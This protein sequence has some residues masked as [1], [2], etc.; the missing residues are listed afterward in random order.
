MVTA[1]YCDE[2]VLAYLKGTKMFVGSRE[3]V[4]FNPKSGKPISTKANE[5]IEKILNLVRIDHRLMIGI[6]VEML[7]VNKESIRKI[8]RRFG[9]EKCMREDCTQK[10]LRTTTI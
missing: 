8:F 2:A 6:I 10:L 9:H 5:N 4:H 1:V 3:D 7:N